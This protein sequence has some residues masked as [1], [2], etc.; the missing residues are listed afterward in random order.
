MTLPDHSTAVSVET[1]HIHPGGAHT[2]LVCVP[3]RHVYGPQLLTALET[4]LA[5][6][7][8][9]PDKPVEQLLCHRHLNGPDTGHQQPHPSTCAQRPELI[10]HPAMLNAH[11][12]AATRAAAAWQAAIGPLTARLPRRFRL[13]HALRPLTGQS[14]SGLRTHPMGQ[15]L[16]AAEPTLADTATEA[17][18]IGMIAHSLGQATFRAYAT[19]TSAYGH[20]LVTTDGRLLRSGGACP[21]ADGLLARL[22]H[23]QRTGFHLGKL[24]DATVFSIHLT[25]PERSQRR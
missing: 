3:G 17:F 4:H 9:A 25:L 19:F 22:G 23:T 21:E 2:V 16:L 11:F 18:G 14:L 15:A 1:Q 10:D 13:N 7:G 20:A 5:R 6:A 24:T 8:L 12:A